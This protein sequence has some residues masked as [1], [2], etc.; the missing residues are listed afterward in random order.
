MRSRAGR[1]DGAGRQGFSWAG[2]MAS[3]SSSRLLC[4][5]RRS[6]VLVDFQ[7]FCSS[8]ATVRVRFA[9]FT[10]DSAHAAAS[11]SRPG[12]D[13]PVAEGVR[14]AG[15]ARSSSGRGVLDKADLH[16]RIWPDT[17]VVDA[18]LNVLIAEIRRALED[19]RARR[20][21]HPH[22]SCDRLCVLRRGRGTDRSPGA[23]EEPRPFDSGWC[24]TSA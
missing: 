13:P 7:G 4:A 15:R 1:R 22:R 21:V 11:A 14:P 19:S 2:A 6:A 9:D 17:Y 24:G 18:N 5:R 16:R 23:P 8:P 10:L 3:S 12:R 20:E